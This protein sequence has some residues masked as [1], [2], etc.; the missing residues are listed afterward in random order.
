MDNDKRNIKLIILGTAFLLLLAMLILIIIWRSNSQ[1][2]AEDRII[3]NEISDMRSESLGKYK[4]F[5][6]T[7]DQ[8]AQNYITSIFS[9]FLNGI[10]DNIYEKADPEYLKYLG[11]DKDKLMQKLNN[12]GLINNF[13]NSTNYKYAEIDSKNIYYAN[14]TSNDKKVN[15]HVVI[16]EKSPNDFKYSFDDFVSYNSTEKE[17][18]K[19]SLKLKILSSRYFISKIEYNV[20]LINNS[21]HNID[22]NNDK[23]YQ[24]IYLKLNT[25]NEYQN[26]T[27]V[28]SGN[29]LNIPPKGEVNINLAFNI[30]ELSGQ[31]IYSLIFKNV[32][33]N[34]D[35][36]YE[37]VE[38]VM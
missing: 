29:K 3:E 34:A 10:S 1:K 27:T 2:T 6:F 11:L 8:I 30:P 38:F 17:Y 15:T 14:V 33:I 35:D 22:I 13:L 36:K 19:N 24:F 28:Y 23:L 25:G 5:N 20:T 18:L 21:D 7:K 12:E 32:N 16:S 26:I 9:T 37:E 31:N 4:T